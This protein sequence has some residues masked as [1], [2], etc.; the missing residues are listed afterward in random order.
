MICISFSA[1]MPYALL[2]ALSLG[3][4]I[5][6]GISTGLDRW[7]LAAYRRIARRRGEHG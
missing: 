1:W 3:L 4:L 2:A 5:G 7:E 6:L